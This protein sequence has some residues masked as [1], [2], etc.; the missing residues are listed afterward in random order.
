MFYQFKNQTANSIDL[1]IYGDI[2]SENK[3]DYDGNIDENA[4]DLKLFKETVEKLGAGQT[5]NMYINSGGGSVFAAS[6]MISMLKRA[7]ERGARAIAHIDG[8]AASAASFFPMAADETHLYSN[9]MIMIHKPLACF[10]LACMNANDLIKVA[11][12]LDAIE[13]GVML[14]LYNARAKISEQK[15]KNL[16]NNETW[17]NAK[18]ITETFDGFILHDEA[19]QAAAC[20]S[21]YFARY[22]NTPGM[23]NTMQMAPKTPADLSVY[24]NKLSK[25]KKA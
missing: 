12:E 20:S 14:P 11:N 2:V 16:V 9:S 13:S 21:Q 6:A 7:Q 18:Q 17:M 10:F 24:R 23:F 4:V 19:K 3:P 25:L 15:I 5:L 22:Q 1:Y 8:L